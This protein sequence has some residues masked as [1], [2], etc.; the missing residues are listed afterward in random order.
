MFFYVEAVQVL[1]V[2]SSVGDSK[3]A[4]RHHHDIWHNPSESSSAVEKKLDEEA[5]LLVVKNGRGSTLPI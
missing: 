2:A 1:G 5:K 4:T 3:F